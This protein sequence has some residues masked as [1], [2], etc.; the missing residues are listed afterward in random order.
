MRYAS[1]FWAKILFVLICLIKWRDYTFKD[2]QFCSRLPVSVIGRTIR[3][4]RHMFC[5]LHIT[6]LLIRHSYP[7]SHAFFSLCGHSSVITT[8]NISSY[9]QGCHLFYPIITLIETNKDVLVNMCPQFNCLRDF[10]FYI[11]FFIIMEIT[12]TFQWQIVQKLI[13]GKLN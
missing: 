6:Y 4:I 8:T 13:K 7:L 1:K 5:Y 9:I 11:Y 2:L 3:F 10:F 12:K